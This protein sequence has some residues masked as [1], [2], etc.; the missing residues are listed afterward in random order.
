MTMNKL[1]RQQIAH[2]L[3]ALQEREG[4]TLE[5]LASK[6]NTTMDAAKTLLKADGCAYLTIKAE[7]LLEEMR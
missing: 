5:D 4:W 7:K 6:L 3:A 2:D 1:P